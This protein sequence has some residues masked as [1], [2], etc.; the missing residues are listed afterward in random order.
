MDRAGLYNLFKNKACKSEKE[1]VE[2]GTDTLDEK[3]SEGE[4]ATVRENGRLRELEKDT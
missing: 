4:G 1:R 2:F 3:E